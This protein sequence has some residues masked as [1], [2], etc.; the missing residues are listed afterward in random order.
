MW[1]RH[2]CSIM[3][4][5]AQ[6]KT[7]ALRVFISYSHDSAAHKETVM[8]LSARLRKDGIDAQIDQ[9]VRGRP[10]EG[11]PRR[12][13]DKLDWADFVLLICTETYY[14]RFRGHEQ[15]GEGKGA[16]WEGQLIT[17]AIYHAKGRIKKFVPVVFDAHH[18]EFA[19]TPL[20]DQVYCLDCEDG[21]RE[22]FAFLTDQGSIPLPELGEIKNSPAKSVKPL[23]FPRVPARPYLQTGEGRRMSD[24]SLSVANRLLPYLVDRA[25]QNYQLRESIENH[26]QREDS[27]PLIFFVHGNT[28][29]CLKYYR[30]CL[31]EE[32]LWKFLGCAPGTTVH[33]KS[34]CWPE[35]TGL[36]QAWPGGA[37][38]ARSIFLRRLAQNIYWEIRTSGTSDDQRGAEVSLEEKI[39]VELRSYLEPLAIEFFL[40]ATDFSGYPRRFLSW[41]VSLW[42]SISIRKGQCCLVFVFVNRGR[43]PVNLVSRTF[44]D[45]LPNRCRR[46]LVKRP[47][48][49]APARVFPELGSVRS[50]H[51][52]EWARYCSSRIEALVSSATDLSAS[53]EEYLNQNGS[54]LTMRTFA[55][56]AA[57]LLGIPL[58][59][60][61][62]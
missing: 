52:D 15:T 20:S 29:Q 8:R 53:L 31:E 27:A 51:I 30:D 22:L 16:D 25:E 21:Y 13:L 14:R 44:R 9:Y 37:E 6:T 36:R 58:F 5:I 60:H 45:L 42:S 2:D 41:F 1:G 49:L 24:L 3:D 35:C 62:E 39:A 28:D 11:W 40:D 48:T 18:T 47:E 4:A 43:A 59:A 32:H 46:L 54:E 55:E 19:P 12:M 50:R 34:V 7:A 17:Q 38:A 26:K 56:K 23:T 57:S 33:F 10:P 61:P